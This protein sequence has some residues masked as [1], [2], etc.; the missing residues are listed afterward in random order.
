MPFHTRVSGI[1]CLPGADR[2]KPQRKRV[3][4]GHTAGEW[5]NA[6]GAQALDP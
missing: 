1:S 4:P 6:G 2:V 5:P 3:T